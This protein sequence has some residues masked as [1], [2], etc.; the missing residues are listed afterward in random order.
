MRELIFKIIT[1]IKLTYNINK[2]LFGWLIIIWC[3]AQL[4]RL[5]L[6]EPVWTAY[7]RPQEDHPARKEYIKSLTEEVGVPLEAH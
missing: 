7:N 1:I 2:A 6:G 4:M 3:Y 5:F